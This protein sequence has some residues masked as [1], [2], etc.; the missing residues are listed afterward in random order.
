MIRKFS[1]FLD[2][3]KIG[4]GYQFHSNRFKSTEI[5]KDSRF[6]AGFNI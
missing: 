1:H 4:K 6:S 2:S 3:I 5:Q